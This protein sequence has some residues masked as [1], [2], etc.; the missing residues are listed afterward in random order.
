MYLTRVKNLFVEHRETWSQVLFVLFLLSSLLV[1]VKIPSIN[2]GVY[3]VLLPL[4]SFLL[5]SL[6]LERLKKIWRDRPT[7]WCWLTLL[8]GWTWVSTIFSDFQ[9]T[10]VKFNIRFSTYYSV[11]L[12][13]FLVLTYQRR[14]KF[15]YY[16]IALRFLVVLATFGT[17]EHFFP[18]LWIFQWLRS[19][20]SLDFY[21]RIS[22]LLQNSNQFGCLMAIGLVLALILRANKQ[23]S[24][25]ELYTSCLLFILNVSFSGSRN[26]WIVLDLGLLLSWLYKVIKPKVFFIITAIW[27]ACMISIPIS[28]D[29]LMPIPEDVVSAQ[30]RLSI[31]SLAVQ[32]IAKNPLTGTGMNVFAQEIWREAYGYN[33]VHAHNLFLSIMVELG[34]PGFLLLIGLVYSLLK[35]AKLEMP[36]TTVL[37]LL[38]LLSQMLDYFMHDYTFTA[39]SLYFLA[40][41]SNSN[42]DKSQD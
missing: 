25:V 1:H 21:P 35:K 40:D 34:I 37:I 14:D 27:M 3:N 41:A 31:W 13:T 6:N 20:A 29:R 36:M 9:Y 5:I 16:R 11:F 38:F 42:L 22:S 23:L 8:Y 39:L 26:A 12:V 7:F 4:F 30:S 24:T 33:G 19:P 10:A 17:I 18:S 2:Y 32:E 28:A 15:S